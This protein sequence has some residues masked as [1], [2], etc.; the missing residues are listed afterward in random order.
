MAVS[1]VTCISVVYGDYWDLF[2]DGWIASIRAL[3][4]AP[5]EVILATDVPRRIDGVRTI[6]IGQAHMADY[7]NATVAEAKTDWIF[8][9]GFDDPWLPHAMMPVDTEADAYGY[10]MFRTGLINDT[11]SYKGGYD[12]IINLNHNPMEGGWFYRTELLRE[13]PFPRVGLLDY[14]HFLYMRAAA[15]TIDAGGPPR[16]TMPRH[17]RA[18]SMYHNAEHEAEIADIKAALRA[19]RAGG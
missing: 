6:T 3:D 8:G 18:H 4:P 14:A 19:E 15:K 17:E 10:P 7:Y 16:S 13:I 12:N 9:G 2:S 11:F 5:A 1:P